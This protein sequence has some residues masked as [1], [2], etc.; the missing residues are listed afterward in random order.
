M[1]KFSFKKRVLLGS[2]IVLLIIAVVVMIM[3]KLD[4]REKG[5]D[6]FGALKPFELIDHK[7]QSYSSS[8]IKTKARVINFMFTTCNGICPVLSQEMRKFQ[9]L[10]Q[11][12]GLLELISISIDPEKDTPKRMSEYIAH[13]K[14]D[15]S[16]WSFLTGELEKIKKI[17]TEDFK[18]GF[19][20]DIQSHTDRFVL[21]DQNNQIRGYYS[22]SDEGS[23]ARLKKDIAWLVHH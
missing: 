20:Q 18:I 11:G 12:Q 8:T 17:M 4:R 14:I 22:M 16:N 3:G 1:A 10:F 13:M 7:S 2:P 9:Q 23:Y 6:Q 5:P 19:H 21:V 15:D